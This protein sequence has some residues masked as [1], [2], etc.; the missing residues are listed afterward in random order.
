MLGIAAIFAF[1]DQP[2]IYVGAFL[3]MIGDILVLR[4]KTFVAGT[5][6]FLFGH[7]CYLFEAMGFIIG[8]QNIEVWQ[9]IVILASFLVVFIPM[10]FICVTKTKH[11]QIEVVGQSLYFAT[12]FVYIPVFIFALGIANSYMYLC[13]V[14]AI[15]FIISDAI[16]VYTHFL[17]KFKRYDFY[18]MLT[19]LIAE[20]LIV[21]GFVLTIATR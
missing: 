2:L 3:G 17:K 7:L 21:A 9:A 8:F 11:N 1:P 14:G 18:I 16:L 10:M 15:F 19:Y 4:T 5:I 6:A 12:Q 20:V 13:L